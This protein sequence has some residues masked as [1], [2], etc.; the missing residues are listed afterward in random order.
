MFRGIFKSCVFIHIHF[1]F[2]GDEQTIGLLSCKI[3]I[4]KSSSS[5]ASCYRDKV[6]AEHE[7]IVFLMIRKSLILRAAHLWKT[8]ICFIRLSLSF[9]T[10]YSVLEMSW[11][12][13]F[14]FVSNVINNKTHTF[15]N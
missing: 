8:V 6:E 10:F 3:L 7:L 4:P 12:N 13:E 14:S 11:V 9:Y 1:N 2:E 5:S 15:K